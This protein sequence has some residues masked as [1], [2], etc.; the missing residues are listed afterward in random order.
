MDAQTTKQLIEETKLLLND[1]ATEWKTV[2]ALW[3]RYVDQGDVDAQFYLADFYFDYFDE[4][5]E[6][7]ELL[8]RAA[9]QDHADATY[10]LRQR[11]P[12]GAERDALL[13]RAGELG[14]LEAQRDLGALYATGDWTGPRDA[15]RATDW[16]RRAAE[17]GHPDAQYNCRRAACRYCVQGHLQR[18]AERAR[19]IAWMNLGLFWRQFGAG[20]IE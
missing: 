16:Y 20:N 5:P 7:K 2:E 13:L 9:D 18:L 17:R 1:D 8:R 6:M 3:R 15:V 14:S 4:G 19:S 11:Y 10:R 12:E